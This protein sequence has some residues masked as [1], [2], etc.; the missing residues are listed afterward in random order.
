[1]PPVFFE[2]KL[3][4]PAICND[5]GCFSGAQ[6]SLN[7]V[8]LAKSEINKTPSPRW[9]LR[10]FVLLF[11]SS[12]QKQTLP[13]FLHLLSQLLLEI[14][15]PSTWDSLLSTGQPL[16]FLS[17]GSGN[18]RHVKGQWASPYKAQ[19]LINFIKG[20][21]VYAIWQP[22]GI[23]HLR[24]QTLFRHH[25]FPPHIISLHFLPHLMLGGTVIRVW[26]FVWPCEEL[27]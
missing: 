11:L 10:C 24:T 4:I 1:M 23:N 12:V 16:F 14:S 22:G 18:N 17:L 3:R 6:H 8:A 27:V 7:F 15:N 25:G 19:N 13:S 5:S 21:S 2:L 9:V 20:G 26:F